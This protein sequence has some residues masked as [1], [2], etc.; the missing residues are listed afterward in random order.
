V[1]LP[2]APTKPP[3]VEALAVANPDQKQP[4]LEVVAAAA[5]VSRATA[6]RVM[7][8]SS[9]VSESARTAVERAVQELG[10]VP[11]RAARNLVT[12]RSDSIAL[13]I[14]E[15][16]QR[17]FSEP[18]FAG[19][20][21]G[22]GQALVD[23]DIQLVLLMAQSPA[24]RER[25]ERYLSSRHVDGAVMISLHGNDPLPRRLTAQGMPAVVGGRP[26]SPE[27][28][29]FVDVDNRRGAFDA[30]AYLVGAGRR[31]VATISGPRDMSVGIDRLIGYQDA[32]SEAGLA[33]TPELIE[34]GDFTEVGGAAAMRSLLDR[35][36]DVDAL[37]AASDLMAA[38]A[39]RVLREAGRTVPGDVA[40]MGFDDS[41]VATHCNPPLSTVHQPMEQMGREMARM[42]LTQIAT[43]DPTP[44]QVVLPTDLVLRESA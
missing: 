10:Y 22:V 37:F 4:T 2:T 1:A 16:G 40:V 23:S 14:T 28:L 43:G 42:L 38:G 20:T 13:V 6:S 34:T 44:Q 8:G 31:R 3:P 17:L 36:P 27:G 11:N 25:L 30:V 39:L 15:S 18:F 12:K 26:T 24:E 32:L 41:L 33:V 19:I 21:R 29:S 7:N 35:A 5:G 9:R